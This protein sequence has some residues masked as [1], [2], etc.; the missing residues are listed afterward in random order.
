[1]FRK[2]CLIG[3][4]IIWDLNC[5]TKI[6]Q[7]EKMKKQI[8]FVLIITVIAA[9]FYILFFNFNKIYKER[10]NIYIPNT[11][12]IR[13]TTYGNKISINI[14]KYN[15]KNIL[16]I[17]DKNNFKEINKDVYKIYDYIQKE[18]LNK[19]IDLEDKLKY[20]DYYLF[21]TNDN[22]SIK[23]DLL[24]LSTKNHQILSINNCNYI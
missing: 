2:R 19:Y 5:N 22:G 12:N 20:Y 9:L 8:I 18:E 6:R 14:L 3:Y 15:K 4:E 10:W 7:G 24:L 23:Y 21:K 16:K 17:L 13:S 11:I 1:M